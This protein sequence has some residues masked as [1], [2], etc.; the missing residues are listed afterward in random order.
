M[1][2]LRKSHWSSVV[3]QENNATN[4]KD[5]AVGGRGLPGTVTH[6]NMHRMQTQQTLARRFIVEFQAFNSKLS[7][8]ASRKAVRSCLF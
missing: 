2:P 6:V 5:K 7:W 3:L 8:T 4:F 1:N